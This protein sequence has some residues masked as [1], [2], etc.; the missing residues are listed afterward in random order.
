MYARDIDVRG[1][2]STPRMT[3][4]IVSGRTLI[5]RDGNHALL[6]LVVRSQSAA[7]VPTFLILAAIGRLAC[8]MRRAGAATMTSYLTA[9]GMLNWERPEYIKRWTTREDL[10]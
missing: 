6:H 9:E 4:Q 5:R 1:K 8:R 3:N 10:Q 7:F 2:D